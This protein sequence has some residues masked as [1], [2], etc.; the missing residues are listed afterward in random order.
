MS[1]SRILTISLITLILLPSML[2]ADSY[3]G[4][5]SGIGFLFSVLILMVVFVCFFLATKIFSLL[6][7]GELASGWQMLAISFIVL[8]LGQLVDLAST[9][10]LFNLD[11]AIVVTF[12]LA[13]VF[14]LLLGI[15]RIKKVLS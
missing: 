13:G 9:L 12:R 11:Q 8:C 15:V 5:T 2:L 6:R 10:E 14:L 3:S 4:S 7:G 1:F